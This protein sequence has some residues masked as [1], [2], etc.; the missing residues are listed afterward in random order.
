M[1]RTYLYVVACIILSAT[2]VFS[3]AHDHDTDKAHAEKGHRAVAHG[4]DADVHAADADVHGADADAHDPHAADEIVLTAAQA[5][6]AG[7]KVEKVSPQP[8]AGIIKVSGQIVSAVGAEH[9]VSATSSGIVTW[10]G[11]SLAEGASV[12]SGQSLAVI[13]A[14]NMQD[15]DPL[16]KAKV[17]CELATRDYERALELAQDQ[18]ISQKE[19]EQRRAAMETARAACQAHSP[20]MTANGITVSSPMSGF[21]KNILVRQGAYVNV[22]DPLLTVTET[23]RLQLR[24]DVPESHVGMLQHISSA[25]FRTAAS[26]QVYR[27]DELHGRLLSYGRSLPSDAFFLPVIFEFDN[28]GDFISGSYAEVWLLTRR[29]ESSLSVPLSAVTEEQGVHFVYVRHA[30]EPYAFPRREVRLGESDGLRVVIR[31]GIQPG[32]EVVVKGVWQVRLASVAS[33]P[34]GHGHQH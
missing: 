11:A 10:T 15:G 23:R 16:A 31:Q 17:A 2:I 13:S 20:N 18:L 3:C 33:L 26:T 22:G 8:F 27:L 28:V 32:D 9:T 1:R 19:L 25:H 6:D 12:R 34:E 21:V 30:G 4:A 29:S 5:R 24:A 7:L 14:K